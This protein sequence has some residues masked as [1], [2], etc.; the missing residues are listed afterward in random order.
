MKYLEESNKNLISLRTSLIAVV[1]LLSGGL[2]G[3]SLADDLTLAKLFWI[4]LGAYFDF[5]F[6]YNIIKI[7]EIIDNNIKKKKNEYK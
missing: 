7:N 4:I 3:L 6:I 5:L 2:V 1:T